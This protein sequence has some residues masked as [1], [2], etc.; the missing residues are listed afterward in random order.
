MR[1][2]K[3]AFEQQTHRVA[4]ITKRWLH[5]DQQITELMPHDKNGLTVG[6]LLAGRRAPMRFDVSQVTFAPHMVFCGNQRVDIGI[7]AV[8]HTVAFQNLVFQGFAG[9]GQ[10][11]GIALFLHGLHGVQERLEHSQISGGAGVA[12]IRREIEN[13]HGHATFGT[14][15]ATQCHQSR[16]P[17]GEHRG[18]LGAGEHVFL[19]VFFGE[20]AALLTA[21][22]GD[23]VGAR[24]SAVNHGNDRTIEFRNRHHDGG[25]DRQQ[26]AAGAAPLIQRLELDRMGGDVRHIELAQNFFGS[27]CVVVGR[28]A[29][30]R[31]TSER[32]D[33]VHRAFTVFEEESFNRRT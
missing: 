2:G 27:V 10:V 13:D 14:F 12:C 30:Q 8:L 5:S 25:F 3:A 21:G 31:E 32:N 33:G 11:D 4:F 18:A 17:H 29:D 23:A 24:A 26:A 16:H 9:F 15:A 22:A 28:A 20:S 1:R 19:V 7:R 6:E